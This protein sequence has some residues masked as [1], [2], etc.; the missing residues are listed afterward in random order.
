MTIISCPSCNT[1]N[2]ID[3]SN[4]TSCSA[5]LAT[6]KFEQSI[7]ELKATTEKLRAMGAPR[8]SF[9]SINGCGTTL[10][11]YRALADGS[12]AATRWVIVFGLPL[13]PLSGYLI[14]P[15]SQE[16]GHGQ[17]TSKFSILDK[18]P[19]SMTRVVR[20]YSLAVVAVLPLL[21]G[22]LNSSWMNRNL[23]GLPA[24]LLMIVSFVWLIYIIFFRLKNEGRAY[25]GKRT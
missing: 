22:S 12:Y 20:T 10:L 14:E 5:S 4:C 16:F 2:N 23:G 21:L 11:D 13:A 24:F 9:Y 3:E 18:T 17:E 25:K 19:L 15:I 7:N 6:A 8:R 1:V